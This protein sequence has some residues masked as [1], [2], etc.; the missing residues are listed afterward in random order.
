MTQM[1]YKIERGFE[2]IVLQIDRYISLVRSDVHARRV[3]VASFWSAASVFYIWGD[4]RVESVVNAALLNAGLSNIT[5][6]KFLVF[7]FVMTLYYSVR[8]AFSI[9][10]IHAEIPMKLLRKDLPYYRDRAVLIFSFHTASNLPSE[11]GGEDRAEYG[12]CKT[13][14][15]DP[16]EKEPT[17]KTAY[18]LDPKKLE[19]LEN[20]NDVRD[21]WQ[22]PT[23][24]WLETRFGLTF[25]PAFLCSVAL[26]LLAKEIWF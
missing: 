24:W 25:L 26:F 12:W 13:M 22:N 3:R 8:L 15:Q 21:M 6:E 1:L 19:K 14:Q 20:E 7:L 5:H 4:L 17:P 16:G 11:K 9:W 10:K 2:E 18:R 23:P